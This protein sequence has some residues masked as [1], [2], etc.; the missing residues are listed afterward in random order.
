MTA[1][2]ED[3]EPVSFLGRPLGRAFAATVVT[4]APRSARPCD[5]SEWRD[6][7]V[8]VE[9]GQVVLERGGDRRVFGQ[10]AVFWLAGL[11]VVALRNEDDVEDVVLV[12]VSRRRP[13]APDSGG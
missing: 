10:G 6:A 1:G 3:C 2:C 11:D 9:H 5:E 4:I 8:V 7:L 12:A 13:D